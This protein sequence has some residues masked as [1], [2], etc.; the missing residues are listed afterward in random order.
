MRLA[1]A[2]I[3]VDDLEES[4]AFY[5]GFLGLR[6]VRRHELGDEATL[7]FLTDDAG[8]YHLELTFNKDG[9]RYEIGDRFGHLA[10]VVDDLD[11]VI[12][13]IEARG[14]SMRES[15]PGNPSRYVFIK[16]PNGLDIEILQAR[17]P[18]TGKRVLARGA[19]D[20]A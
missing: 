19:S 3:R 10:F 5:T 11:A 18:W 4:V 15:R 13:A 17:T 8:H 12:E 14:W 9:R 6:E 1:H 7:A 20:P 16:D 2:M